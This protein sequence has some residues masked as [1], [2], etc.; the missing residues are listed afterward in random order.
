MEI[1]LALTLA[2]FILFYLI[3]YIKNIMLY[4]SMYFTFRKIKKQN[5][6]P[7]V[8]QAM[9]ELMNMSKELIKEEEL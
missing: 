7:S 9:D 2:I 5:V 8:K 1:L 3:P 4:I 6:H